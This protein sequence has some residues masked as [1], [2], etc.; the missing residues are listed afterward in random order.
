[1]S[2]E[3]VKTAEDLLERFEEMA[4]RVL[5]H[6][7]EQDLLEDLIDCLPFPVVLWRGSEI[8]SVNGSFCR[9]T[10]YSSKE[11]LHHHWHEF[12]LQGEEKRSYDVTALQYKLR[13][14]GKGIF[15]FTNKWVTKTGEPIR[16]WWWATPLI[17]SKSL[18]ICFCEEIMLG[19]QTVYEEGMKEF[20]ENE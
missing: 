13:G 10:G 16:I 4:S 3:K 5:A 11:L 12:L 8:L 6:G 7:E 19:F 17:G 15:G 1:M 18:S 14:D 9:M 2:P 20:P